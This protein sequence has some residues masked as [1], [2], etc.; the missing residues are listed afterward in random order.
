[1]SEEPVTFHYCSAESKVPESS[2]LPPSNLI[3]QD[4]RPG[5]LAG[6]KDSFW[7]NGSK[8]KVKF[9]NGTAVQKRKAKF[10]AQRWEKFA[11][12][13]FRFIDEGDADIR[14]GFRWLVLQPLCPKEERKA[15]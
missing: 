8:L 1:M 14:V 15:N 12:I 7:P 9:L 4:G 2:E 6:R 5:F 3:T 10:Y 13:D 11:N